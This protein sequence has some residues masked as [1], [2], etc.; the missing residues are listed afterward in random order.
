MAAVVLTR[1]FSGPTVVRV[2]RHHPE[3][4]VNVVHLGT[5]RERHRVAT[6]GEAGRWQIEGIALRREVIVNTFKRP[7]GLEVT[8]LPLDRFKL[9][10]RN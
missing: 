6:L 2:L 9:E 10:H 5:N 3:D 7:P 8:M 4:L 1:D